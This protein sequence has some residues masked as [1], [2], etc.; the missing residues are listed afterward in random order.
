MKT[1]NNGFTLI[2]LLV[3]I[4]II[5]ILAGMVLVSMGGARSKARDAKRQS[6]MRQV[7]SA[8]EMYY[9]NQD[10]YYA[11]N[12]ATVDALPASI[13]DGTTVFLTVPADPGG[14]TQHDCGSAS[15][16][17]KLYRYCT[18]NNSTS[19]DEQKFCYYAQLENEITNKG[20]C[21][22]AAP[23]PYITATNAG[24]FYKPAEPAGATATLK[25]GDCASG[26]Q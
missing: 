2:E 18:I 20:T 1:N 25:L 22:A 9:G 21:T 8:Q 5:G 16:A 6:D 11:Y 10:K 3:V 17:N 7:I 15:S 24:T 19:G 4:A 26:V 23:C 12:P 14:G 13:I